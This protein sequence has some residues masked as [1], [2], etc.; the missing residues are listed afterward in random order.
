MAGAAIA[1][2]EP[3]LGVPNKLAVVV[4]LLVVIALIVQLSLTTAA[5]GISVLK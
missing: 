2:A 4:T 1:K 5:H 3:E